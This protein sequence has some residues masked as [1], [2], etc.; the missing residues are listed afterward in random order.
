[1]ANINIK[2]MNIAKEAN[3][4]EKKTQRSQNFETTKHL[5]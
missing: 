1:V 4:L 5:K 3:T 2:N